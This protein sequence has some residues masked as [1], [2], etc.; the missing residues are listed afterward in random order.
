MKAA[1]ENLSKAGQ[2]L[3]AKAAEAAGASG[4]PPPAG[5]APE[6]DAGAPRKTEKQADVVDADF[7]V[8]DEDNKK[9]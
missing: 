8:V 3:Y 5:A 2:E 6:S 9:K 7:E 1:M 4:T